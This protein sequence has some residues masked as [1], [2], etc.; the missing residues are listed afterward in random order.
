MTNN[1]DYLKNYLRQFEAALQADLNSY[2]RGLDSQ[3]NSFLLGKIN[4]AEEAIEKA[5]K[6][7]IKQFEENMKYV[8][9]ERKESD[10]LMKHSLDLME[11]SI[12]GDFERGLR[13]TTNLW[14][15]FIENCKTNMR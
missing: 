2:K 8:E 4:E 1:D 5:K 10:S 11:K 13:M 3:L 7:Y 6:G 12:R 9:E 15:A 14:K